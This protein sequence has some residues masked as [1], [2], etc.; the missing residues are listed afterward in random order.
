MTAIVI[1]V[2]IQIQAQI[3]IK[4]IAHMKEKIINVIKNKFKF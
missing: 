4:M 3:Q 1:Q 2:H